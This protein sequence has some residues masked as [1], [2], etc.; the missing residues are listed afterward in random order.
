MILFDQFLKCARE[1]IKLPWKNLLGREEPGVV[2]EESK[3]LQL[4]MSE[5]TNLMTLMG[6]ASARSILSPVPLIC[7]LYMVR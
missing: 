4:E 2:N 6:Q 7:G 3:C 1:L 5:T